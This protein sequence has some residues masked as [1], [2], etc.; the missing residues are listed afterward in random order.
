MRKGKARIK[1]AGHWWIPIVEK[2]WTFPLR[3]QKVEEDMTIDSTDFKTTQVRKR[4]EKMPAD[5]TVANR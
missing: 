5:F 4:V 1:T 2:L 3:R